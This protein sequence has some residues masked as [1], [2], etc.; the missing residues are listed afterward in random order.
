MCLL[1][2]AATDVL[3]QSMWSILN[4]PFTWHFKAKFILTRLFN[5]L[6]L[7]LFPFPIH[8]F[9]GYVIHWAGDKAKLP[10]TVE[11]LILPDLSSSVFNF[12]WC[13]G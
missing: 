2:T 5:F 1:S 4:D 8:P 11:A 10:K 6:I 12:K 3:R 13:E 9:F 7:T